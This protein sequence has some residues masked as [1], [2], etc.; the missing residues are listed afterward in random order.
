MP[1]NNGMPM[2]PGM[3]GMPGMPVNG[4]MPSM[5][6]S[7][8]GMMNTS[9]G[10]SSPNKT[11]K[12]ENAPS[13]PAATSTPM[14]PNASNLSVD[15]Q[16]AYQHA[17]L[18]NAVAQNMQIQQQL[19]M[20]NQALS[21]LLSQTSNVNISTTSQPKS[22]MSP[23]ENF[24]PTQ[25]QSTRSIKQPVPVYFGMNEAQRRASETQLNSNNQ[26]GPLDTKPRSKTAPNTPKNST[27]LPPQ[28][29][30][31]P[32]SGGPM[33]AYTRART[34]RIGKWR[35][36]PPKEDG[37][38]L[39]EG[40]FEFKMRKMKHKDDGFDIT[41]AKNES[42]ETSGEIQGLDWSD[43]NED[44]NKGLK[45]SQSKD[46]FTI[47]DDNGQPREKSESPAKERGAL[48][49]SKEG[50]IPD[51]AVKKL[52]EN[53][54]LILEQKL[55]GGGKLKKWK[56]IDNELHHRATEENDSSRKSS[57][58][59]KGHIPAPPPPPI[60]PSFTKPL[61]VDTDQRGSPSP[62]SS[63]YSPGGS[64]P[65]IP[66]SRKPPPPVAPVL[67]GDI[68]DGY[69]RKNDRERRESVSTHQTEKTERYEL[70]ESSEF[71]QPTI[72]D[73]DRRAQNILDELDYQAMEE[74][75]T[76]LHPPN[77]N[78]HFS[79]NR[80]PWKLK[81]RKEVF[82]P[83]E[84]LT[85]PTTIHVVFCQIVFDTFSPL[86]IRLTQSERRKMMGYMDKYD[87]DPKNV[88]S[89]QH[90]NSTKI[91]ILAMAKDFSTYFSRIYPVASSDQDVDVQYLAVSH[92]GVKLVRRE[93][94]L[95]TDY[96]KVVD[97]Y[98]FED[99]G[100]VSTI[101][102]TALQLVM[103]TGGRVVVTTNKA[104]SIRDLINQFSIEARS[105][106]YEYA[107]ALADYSS[108]DDNALNFSVGEVIAVVQKE[109]AY[110]QRG[111][112]YGIK[113]GKYGIFPADFVEKMSPKSIRREIK[114]ISR[115][116]QSSPR[117][118]ASQTALNNITSE[119]PEDGHPAASPIGEDYS[120]GGTWNLRN[121]RDSYEAGDTSD[122][123]ISA[124]KVSN[125]GK[126][127]LL[128]FAM[129]YFR[130]SNN[131]DAIP[132]D[133]SIKDKKKK[134]KKNSKNDWTWKD[135]VE[136]VKWTERMIENSLMR[137]EQLEMNKIA[138]E[139]FAS[140]MRYMGDMALM[141]NQLDV[142]CAL[143][144]L[145]YCYKFDD[146]KDEVYCQIM[147]QTTNNKSAV[148]DSCQKGWRLFSIIAAYFTCSDHLKPFLFKY[149]ETAAYDKR[150]AYHGTALV[151]LHNLRKT[152]KYGGRKMAPSIEEITAI[153]AGRN[154][155][156]QIYR[157]PGGTE[158][159]INTKSTTVVDDIVEELC[160]VIGVTSP[161]EREEFSL[162]CIIEGQTFTRPL[163]KEQ[164]ILDVPPIYRSRVRSTI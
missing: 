94:S 51:Q 46:S 20:Q 155:K 36:P 57:H 83:S 125:D 25:T 107:R 43:M 91:N 134:K 47:M 157:L 56:N 144:I 38:A 78:M 35:W 116:T 138:L 102:S 89:S 113:D 112:L 84:Q 118:R 21:Q 39:A 28:A 151:C 71:L 124:A 135:Q 159:V 17:F 111:W 141:K 98:N 50:D 123:S 7:S 14:S 80:V 121:N 142:D 146:M 54:K 11:E 163:Y 88:H 143:T 41:D 69:R 8:M 101:K 148:P 152:F 117:Q 34:V 31:L 9:T 164:Y 81:V 105:G 55:G 1:V 10:P 68:V 115:I 70:E 85:N 32:S 136:L 53:R 149:L 24:S 19:M 106:Q 30:M 66:D 161:H 5:N 130:E 74:M 150:R 127:P 49:I 128:E 86:C 139:C 73:H 162:Y 96:L 132:Q 122:V 90:K 67:N 87:I 2:M 154:S 158:R 110:T 72:D 153:T 100:E 23:K 45:R 93:K 131:F 42:L 63:Y 82:S 99:I 133:G 104:A 103:H 52:N 48:D 26:N 12:S 13:A 6:Y 16:M 40:F 65:V 60:A 75:Q 156:R 95:P 3:P 119:S 37:E 129:S 145:S 92:T 61:H 137:L 33:D 29:P 114:V 22:S 77:S 147:K 59:S 27:N 97:F 108:R 58:D 18:Q 4:S 109:D 15:S 79:Y 126:H 62:G 120:P 76:R 44:F 64:T 140:I 160:T